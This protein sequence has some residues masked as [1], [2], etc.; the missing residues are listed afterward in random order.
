MVAMALAC[1]SGNP[2]TADASTPASNNAATADP[3][4][5]TLEK[6]KLAWK[7]A[8][9]QGETEIMIIGRRNNE[10]VIEARLERFQRAYQLIDE[11]LESE[12]TPGRPQ[13]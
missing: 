2:P 1:D 5:L 4:L 10:E 13:P 3:A 7:M 11:M 12:T 8:D 9:I 6:M